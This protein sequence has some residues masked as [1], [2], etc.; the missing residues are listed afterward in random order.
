MESSESKLNGSQQINC[1]EKNKS[2][3]DQKK[4]DSSSEESSNSG[5]QAI[6]ANL[7]EVIQQQLTPLL[8]SCSLPGINITA[9][10]SANGN[11]NL[12]SLQQQLA[13]AQV[14]TATQ[15]QRSGGNP[16]Q[17]RYLNT[18]SLLASQLSAAACA[19]AAVANSEGIAPKIYLKK[20]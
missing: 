1:T 11:I 13:V 18:A 4:F 14:A 20:I 17:Q 5:L 3:S 2:D 12:N 7:T 15:L 10:M 9:A 6:L 19:A 8:E 16:N